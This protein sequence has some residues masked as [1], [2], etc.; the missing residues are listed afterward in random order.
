MKK[1]RLLEEEEEEEEKPK[2]EGE[3]EEREAEE[4]RNRNPKPEL[5]K[6]RM[7]S[8]AGKLL[9]VPISIPYAV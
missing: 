8:L 5:H 1:R 7:P 6:F 4:T 2:R 9:K 3:K